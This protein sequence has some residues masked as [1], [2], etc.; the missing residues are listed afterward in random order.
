MTEAMNKFRILLC[1]VIL[2]ASFPFL[3]GWGI[4]PT[5]IFGSILISELITYF[6]TER[7]KN[8]QGY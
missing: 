5:I 3:F 7:R 8:E 2:I 6:K 4:V 1:S